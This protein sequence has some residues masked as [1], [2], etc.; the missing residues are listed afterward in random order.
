MP[1]T[2][3]PF[4]TDVHPGPAGGAAYWLTAADGVRIRIGVWPREAAKGTVL[5]FPGRTEY[6]EK[7]G[8]TAQ[9]LADRGFATLA[10]DWRGQGLADRLLDDWRIGHV[11]Q[12]SEYQ[13]DVQ[14]ALDAARA[15]DLPEPF[16]LLGH[17]MGGCIGL[18]ALMNGLP[19]QA[20]AFTGPMWRVHISAH[21]RPVAQVL[22]RLMPVLG[23]G[24]KL[25]PATKISSYVQVQPFEDNMLTTDAEM[26]DMMRDQLAA[27]PELGLGGPSYQWLRAAL[28]ETRDLNK[29]PAPPVPCVTWLGTN[30][31]IVD[32]PRIHARMASWPNG[33]L[34]MVPGGEHEVLMEGAAIRTNIMD[35]MAKHF[36]AAAAG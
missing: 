7:Y 36:E 13:L 1:L 32:A 6:I 23:L 17:S 20:A 31:R 8:T 21:L 29:H 35:D 15:L 2:P 5:L 11:G 10:V 9:D 27:H 33:R 18:R 25:L 24:G 28:V 3:A 16:F 34:E 26:Y 19:V 30:E 4:F 22:T 14:A 12:F